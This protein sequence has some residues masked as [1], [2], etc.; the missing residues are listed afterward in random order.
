VRRDLSDVLH[1]FLPELSAEAVVSSEGSRHRLATE[2][3][4]DETASLATAPLL[5]ILALPIADSDVV[6]TA[7]AWNL[8]V[9]VGRLGAAAVVVAPARD[10]D[11]A[12]WPAISGSS[13]AAEV[14]Y[15]DGDD[16]PSLHRAAADAAVSGARRTEDGGLVMVRIP[17]AELRD[18][19][20]GSPL[21]RWVLLFASNDPRD[22]LE[23]FGL[24]RLLHR[25]RED[26]E[27]G[28]TLHGIKELSNA[29]ESFDRLEEVSRRRAGIA[30]QS[31]GALVDD[32]DVYRA[33][34]AERAVG[35]AHPQSPAA[36]ALC[37]VARLLLQR[38]RETEL[39]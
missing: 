3:S 26:I 20:S 34:V 13:L 33:I 6:R 17:P 14:L 31:Y 25:S 38:A 39:G 12:L 22:L 11:S 35:L 16:L 19:G 7:L 21:L 18:L 10:R 4:Q 27:I 24:A 1:Y 5:S 30:L 32:L 9:E 15:A 28:V 37:D 36:R 8:A 23:T 2:P 29:E